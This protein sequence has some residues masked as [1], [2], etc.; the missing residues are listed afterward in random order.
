MMKKTLLALAL[1]GMSSTASASLFYGGLTAG[2]STLGNQ[3]ELGTGFYLGTGTLF[4]FPFVAAEVGYI[5]HGIGN[6][7]SN[8]FA[9]KPNINLGPFHVYA[10]GGLD[11]YSNGNDN[12]I[13]IMYG[14]G[15]EYF[16]SAPISVGLNFMDYGLGNSN[17]LT[18]INLNA[19]FHFL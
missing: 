5:D 15:V 12:G 1:I 4:P 10:K 6:L 16:V 19:T 7:N 8:Y 17:D 18:S 13:D 14:V 2:Q 11:M 9:L 3:D